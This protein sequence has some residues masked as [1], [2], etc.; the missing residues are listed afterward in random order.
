MSRLL[1]ALAVLACALAGLTVPAAGAAT[2][3]GAD[4]R[5]PTAGPGVCDGVAG[6]RVVASVDVDGDGSRDDVGVAGRGS[7]ASRTVVVRVLVG[8]DQVV[9]TR[10]PSPSWFGSLWEGA[11]SID[12]RRGAELMVGYTQGAHTLFSRSLTWRAGRLVTLGAPGPGSFW[13]TDSAVW[14]SLGWQHLPRDPAGSIRELSAVRAASSAHDPFEGTVTRYQW[15]PR[16]WRT[17]ASRT[18]FPLSD[19]AA[20]DWGGFHVPGLARW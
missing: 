4:V 15:T 8:P 18:V 20:Y 10:V 5:A 12:R 9:A 13:V 2:R 16:G 11:A 14:I 6:C 17:V 3:G 19:R 1:T 7:G